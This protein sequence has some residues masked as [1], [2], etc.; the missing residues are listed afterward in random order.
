VKV[1]PLK[2]HVICGYQ[3]MV[4]GG[5]GETDRSNGDVR[6]A[7]GLPASKSGYGWNVALVWKECLR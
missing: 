1:K 5:R 2:V 7:S 4:R 6:R 3:V